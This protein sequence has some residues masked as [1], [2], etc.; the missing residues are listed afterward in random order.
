MSAAN[1]AFCL[2]NSFPHH[3][4]IEWVP[5]RNIFR[6]VTFPI[7]EQHVEMRNSRVV[8]CKKTNRLVVQPSTFPEVKYIMS[9]ST[10]VIGDERRN[11]H[12]SQEIG[13][14]GIS[15]INGSDFYTVKFKRSDRIRSLGIMNAGI[16][17]EGGIAPINPLFIFQKNVYCK[18]IWKRTCKVLT[19]ELAPFLLSLVNGECMRKC[20]KTSIRSKI[21]G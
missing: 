7:S 15:K 17:I 3:F 1:C 21:S 8:K 6:N 4:E 18:R 5:L 20:V 13:Y 11:C 2:K 19:N 10:G 14:I 9:I 12:I 16:Q